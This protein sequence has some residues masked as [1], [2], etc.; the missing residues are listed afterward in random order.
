MRGDLLFEMP[1]LRKALVDKGFP[2]I[3]LFIKFGLINIF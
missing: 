2:I 3:R 1:Y